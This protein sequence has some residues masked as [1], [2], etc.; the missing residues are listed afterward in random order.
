[1]VYHGHGFTWTELYNMPVWL[2]NFYYKKI[3]DAIIEKNK[4]TE[5]SNKNKSTSKPKITK[6]MIG[7]RR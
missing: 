6:P 4:I 5:K 2:R 1:M 3:E 7:S